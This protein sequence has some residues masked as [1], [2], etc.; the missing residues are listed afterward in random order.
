MNLEYKKKLSGKW[1]KLKYLNI[2]T[3]SNMLLF[4]LYVNIIKLNSIYK[5]QHS[6][7]AYLKNKF[8]IQLNT[9]EKFTLYFNIF[10]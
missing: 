10:K 8:N 7:I 4:I 9:Y 2:Q 6:I 3:K 1:Q 5:F